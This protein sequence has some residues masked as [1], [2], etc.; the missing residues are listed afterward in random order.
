MAFFT[1]KIWPFHANILNQN[2]SPRQTRWASV[3]KIFYLD[4]LVR[5]I[6][7]IYLRFLARLDF[8]VFFFLGFS[9]AS[10]S[11]S[12]SLVYHQAARITKATTTKITSAV[13]LS[14]PEVAAVSDEAISA[15]VKLTVIFCG[16]VSDWWV[17]PTSSAINVCGPYG[18]SEK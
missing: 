11:S 12:S 2:K 8:L 14:K 16:G 9:S 17:L 10:S 15:L 13:F 6:R 5:L 18:T 3:L 7:S 4:Q 1:A